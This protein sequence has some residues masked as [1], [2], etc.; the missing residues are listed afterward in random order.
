MG[1][2]RWAWAALAVA[3]A[4]FLYT[5]GDGALGPETPATSFQQLPL[6]AGAGRLVAGED[7]SAFG[8]SGCA[9][10]LCLKASFGFGKGSVC[11]A[12]CEGPRNCPRGWQCQQLLAGAP[13][14][15]CIPPQGFAPKAVAIEAPLTPGVQ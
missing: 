2:Q 4:A 7:C 14:S 6:E 15:H 1:K 12:E 10:K 9:S 13:V 5:C 3:G 11:S 8:E